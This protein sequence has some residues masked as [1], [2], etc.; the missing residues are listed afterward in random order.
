M[1]LAACAPGDTPDAAQ[2]GLALPEG[3]PDISAAGAPGAALTGVV[4][5]TMDGG[6]YTF[7]RIATGGRELW[8]A[9]PMTPLTVGDEVSLPDTLPMANFTAKSV[10]RTFDVLY[11]TAGFQAP[12]DVTGNAEFEGTVTESMN[13][14]GYTYVQVEAGESTLWIAGPEIEIPENATVAWNGGMRMVDFHSSTLDRTFDEIY[15]VTQ[16]FVVQ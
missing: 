6:G 4:Q 3:H 12:G 2:G 14:G 9:G 16:I 15:F 8:A 5:E 13:S 11:F 10:D 1:T 7:A